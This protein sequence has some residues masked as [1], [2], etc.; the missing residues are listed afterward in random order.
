MLEKIKKLFRSQTSR[1]GG[2]SVGLITAVIC[3]VIVINMIAGQLPENIRNIDISDNKIYEITDTS[4]E[5]LDDL[6][7]EVSFTVYAEKNNTDE[8]IQ[9]FLKKY[10]ALSDKID[11]EWVDPVQHPSALTE[12]NVESDTILVNCE[13]TGKSTTV[14][15][16]D[17]LV[18]DEY[19]Y[20]TS[21]S[22]TASEFDGEGQLT[23]AVNYVTST[24]SGKIY[25]T[26]GHG[27]QA[28]SSS[29]T[30]LLGK[31]NMEEEELN[32]LMDSEIPEDCD[33]LF[34]NAPSSDLTE[35]ERDSI[36]DYM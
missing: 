11:V 19:A 22:S 25:Y 13:D 4:R 36:L 34:V 32:L 2:Y 10:A 35:D 20:Y 17:I 23:S 31:N 33:L 14:G 1:N 16:S 6:D 8:R 3:I 5:L 9:T 18:V 7:S 15:F 24:D 12:N 28:F 30:D 26:S 29:V 27:E 21:G